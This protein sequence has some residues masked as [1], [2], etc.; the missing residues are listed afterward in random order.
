MRWNGLR[1][2]NAMKDNNIQLK[3]GDK[4]AAKDGETFYIACCDCSLVHKIKV[5]TGGKV[6]KLTFHRDKRRTTRER[7][8]HNVTMTKEYEEQ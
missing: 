7:K 1:T 4:I 8:Q 5:S 6:V 3:D 2:N